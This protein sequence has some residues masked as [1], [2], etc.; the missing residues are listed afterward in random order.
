[1]DALKAMYGLDRLN[2]PNQAQEEAKAAAAVA[3]AQVG[4]MQAMSLKDQLLAKARA[5]SKS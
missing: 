2:N 5:R 1:M 3:A 4:G